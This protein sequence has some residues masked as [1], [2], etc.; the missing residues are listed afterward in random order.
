MVIVLSFFRFYN[1]LHLFH[2][3]CHYC[4]TQKQYSNIK[5]SLSLSSDL[6]SL[7]IKFKIKE[8]QEKETGI[9]E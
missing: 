9:T 7:K 5:A 6:S 2:S 1:Y 4:V 3:C 8:Q